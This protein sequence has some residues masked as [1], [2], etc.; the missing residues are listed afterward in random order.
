MS[1]KEWNKQQLSAIDMQGQ[2]VVVSAA[3]GSGKTSV[4][5]ERVLRLIEIGED[6]SRML[7][8]TFTNLAAGEMR[9]RIHQRLQEAGK[10]DARLAAQAEKCASRTSPRCIRSAAGY[11]RQLRP[12]GRVP[13]VRHRG[14]SGGGQAAANCAGQGYRGGA[15]G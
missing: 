3:A 6:L 12:G 7:V 10:K 11:S 15:G 5:A 14:R 2:S 9:S 1:K 4:L 13:H 8:V